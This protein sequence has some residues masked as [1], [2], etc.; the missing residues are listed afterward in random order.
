MTEHR[1]A[2]R[3]LQVWN[4]KYLTSA[5]I[6]GLL[7]STALF[8]ETPAGEVDFQKA[9]QLFQR[10]Q[11]GEALTAEERAYLERA[12]AQ[13]DAQEEKRE[14]SGSAPGADIDWDKARKLFQREQ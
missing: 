11:A 9:R 6:A 8:A 2:G 10:Q 13:H 5:L 4:M 14:P 12:K 1:F 7:A 3:S